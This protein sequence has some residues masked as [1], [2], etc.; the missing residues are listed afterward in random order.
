[1]KFIIHYYIFR[2]G[3]KVYFK[4]FKIYKVEKL[5][6]SDLI[7]PSRGRLRTRYS[8]SM[9]PA[10][11]GLPLSSLMKVRDL[12]R[13]SVPLEN[14]RRGR[15]T[16]AVVGLS[17]LPLSHR[18]LGF[19]V[20]LSLRRRDGIGRGTDSYQMTLSFPAKP[21]RTAHQ[22][23]FKVNAPQAEVYPCNPVTRAVRY[24]RFAIQLHIV[25]TPARRRHWV[26]ALLV[27]ESRARQLGFIED[28]YLVLAPPAEGIKSMKTRSVF[29]L[30]ILVYLQMIP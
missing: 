2:R 11:P 7:C 3:F 10:R 29:Y 5:R 18:T 13:S 25:K 6:F 15:H 17:D 8:S 20:K 23:M 1:M 26:Q 27:A 24:V 21:S 19:F 28:E 9:K 4:V 30:T 22:P 12:G 14:A 16:R